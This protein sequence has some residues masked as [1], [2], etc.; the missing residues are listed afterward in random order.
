MTDKIFQL[1]LKRIKRRG[2]QYKKE[3][4]L[5]DAY[6]EYLPDRKRRKVSNI[7]LVTIVVA[8]VLYTVASFWLQY[9]TGY[10]IDSTLTTCFY[11]FWGSELVALATLKTSKI[12]KGVNDDE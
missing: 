6:A 8:I 4:K 12:I 3:K 2:E 10:A 7:M 11:T 9:K 1:R 5:R